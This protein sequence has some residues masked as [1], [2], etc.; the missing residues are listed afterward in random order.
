M[1]DSDR[2][3]YFHFT[4]PICSHPLDDRV[5]RNRCLGRLAMLRLAT[6]AELARATGVSKQTVGR[7]RKRLQERGESGFDRPRKPRRLHGIDDPAVLAR[8]AGMLRDGRSLNQVAKAL[9]VSRS[10]LWR[11]SRDG[12]LPPSQVPPWSGRKP[13]TASAEE[14]AS[15]DGA[16]SPG[17]DRDG[18]DGE[19]GPTDGESVGREERNLRDAAA[20]M[21]RAAHDV[22]GRVAASLGGL[23][24]REPHFEPASSLA[25]GGVLAAL[26]ALLSAGLLRVEFH[27]ISWEERGFVS[28]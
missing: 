20:S 23:D 25:C 4:E 12:I 6:A 26:P 14:G 7:A 10:T 2:A 24:G 28:E 27:L 16:E 22:E 3:V 21:G 11:Y 19:P 15:G 13:E 9:S 17:P 18:A 8:A 5:E 1:V